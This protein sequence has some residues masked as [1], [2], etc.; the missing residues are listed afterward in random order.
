MTEWG[1]LQELDERLQG[2]QPD[3]TGT[4][5]FLV[6]GER[7]L[8]I[9]KKRGHGAGK[10]NAPG[11][12]LE[13]GESVLECA[14][15]ETLEETGVRV[16]DARIMARLRFVERHGEQW[17]GYALIGSESSGAPVETEEARPQ[18]FGLGD[19]PYASMWEDDRVWLP[20]I[21]A[22]QRVAGDFL[23]DHGRLLAYRIRDAGADLLPG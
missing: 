6:Q 13:E 16:H 9:H 22:G 23:F 17:L 4:L 1:A 21:L 2:W 20:Q 12:K 7:V 19:I 15:R 8:L 18:W 3:V 14:V 5:L 10:I 11:G